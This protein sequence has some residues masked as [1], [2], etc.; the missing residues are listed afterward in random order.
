MYIFM[1][2]VIAMYIFLFGVSCCFSLS[3]CRLVSL[4]LDGFSTSGGSSK[5]MRYHE[6]GGA[7]GMSPGSVSYFRGPQ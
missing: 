3:M 5:T 4:P 7:V 2:Q 6:R 1:M